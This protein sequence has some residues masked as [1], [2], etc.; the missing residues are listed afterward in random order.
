ME[1]SRF[2][3]ATQIAISGTLIKSLKERSKNKSLLTFK[4][5]A[6]K[7]V[8][9]F[10]QMNGVQIGRVLEEAPEE[11]AR[12]LLAQENI[13]PNGSCQRYTKTQ[14]NL[15]IEVN[16]LKQENASLKN[17]VNQLK[18]KLK[19]LTTSADSMKERSAT[20]SLRKEKIW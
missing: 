20:C 16:V 8:T 15:E 19:K 6:T 3:G 10:V 2:E 18:Q 4:V 13:Q 1:G 7:I 17:Q 14:K 11:T 5:V 9:T 12:V